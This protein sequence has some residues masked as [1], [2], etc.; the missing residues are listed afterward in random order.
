MAAIYSVGLGDMGQLIERFRT[1]YAPARVHIEYVHPDVVYEKVLGRTAEL[2]LVSFPRKQREL[3]ILPWRDEEMMLACVPN[4]PLARLR[5]IEP[6]QLE[7]IAYVAF[8]KDLSIRR[9]VDQFLRE[10]G[11][12]VAVESEI[13]TIEN[14]KRMIE[15]GHGVALLPQ[16]T[17]CQ[18]VRAGSLVARPLE[19]CRFVRPIG[20]I[21]RR[22][23]R[24]SGAANHFI[25][26]LQEC[27]NTP[28][29]CLNGHAA[30]GHAPKPK[31]A[32]ATRKR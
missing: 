2:G 15:V 3:T 14:I 18:E 7:N 21:H 27:G 4:H 22:Q 12:T 26:L 23:P 6:L 11:V 29:P 32:A 28:A 8:A 30:N 24:L 1:R 20:I 5:S 13:E 9:R 25:E 10:H 19:G 17:F 31:H 16:P